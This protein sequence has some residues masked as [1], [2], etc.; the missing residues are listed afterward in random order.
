MFLNIYFEI[1]G[2]I[3]YGKVT[4]HCL[5]EGHIFHNTNDPGHCI[6]YKIAYTHSEGSDQPAHYRHSISFSQ[7]TLWLAKELKRL[8]ANRI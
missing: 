3:S 4:V 1:F 5:I 7:V 6:S 2:T 8:K